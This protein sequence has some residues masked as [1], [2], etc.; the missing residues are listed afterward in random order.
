MDAARAGPARPPARTSRP[1]N[2][3]DGW[4]EAER[5]RLRNVYL[6][7]RKQASGK[8][9]LVTVAQNGGM[10]GAQNAT[11]RPDFGLTLSPETATITSGQSVRV[12]VELASMCELAGTIDVGIHNIS[13]LPQGNN[14]FTIHQPRYD[15]P[16][17]ANG[18]AVAYITLGATPQTAKTTYT[19]T[20]AGK[21]VSG[22]CCYG[23]THSATFVLKVI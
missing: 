23:I 11:C 15:I 16:L 1:L 17:D 21:D 18:T 3:Y 19:I 22:G 2:V 7:R 5:E 20:I 8:S 9:R 4:L 13:P 10:G 6:R 12:S 14:G